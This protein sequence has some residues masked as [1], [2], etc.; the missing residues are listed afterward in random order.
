M[1][2]VILISKI[3]KKTRDS[4]IL[5]LKDCVFIL[6]TISTR[7]LFTKEKFLNLYKNSEVYGG[8]IHPSPIPCP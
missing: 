8:L 7:G 1:N 3:Q 5:S 6:I 4:E 2:V